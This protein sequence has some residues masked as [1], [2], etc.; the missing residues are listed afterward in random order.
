MITTL[1]NG[2]LCCTVRDDLIL[3]LNR[4]VRRRGGSWGGQAEGGGSC[5]G[6][7]SSP[8]SVGLSPSWEGSGLH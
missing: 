6:N 1:S 4:L 8:L 2:C 5:S 3:A 7:S